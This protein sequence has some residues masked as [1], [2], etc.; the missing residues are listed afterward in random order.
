MHGW[1][2]Q[3]R[4]FISGPL[5]ERELKGAI[6]QLTA[7]ITDAISSGLDL[8]GLVSIRFAVLADGRVSKVK[9]LADTTRSPGEL[10]L[11]R[12]DFVQTVLAAVKQ[13]QFTKQRGISTVTLP[14]VFEREDTH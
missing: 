3:P 9:L 10:D 7:V 14:L 11:V 5:K 4:P 1:F 6:D 13:L 8:A 2:V 12:V